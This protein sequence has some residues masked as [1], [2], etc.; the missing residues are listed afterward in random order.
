MFRIGSSQVM[1]CKVFQSGAYKCIMVYSGIDAGT[2]F[3]CHVQAFPVQHIPSEERPGTADVRFSHM[4]GTP[5]TRKKK[6]AR[7]V[8]PGPDFNF[9]ALPVSI[10]RNESFHFHMQVGAQAWQISRAK[11]N[12]A[13]ALAAFSAHPAIKSLRRITLLYCGWVFFH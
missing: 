2:E 11:H 10:G 3:F 5:R 9:F 1:F 6:D 12:T 4:D 8:R 13:F 7:I